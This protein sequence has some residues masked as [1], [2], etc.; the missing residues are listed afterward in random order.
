MFGDI[1]NM[2]NVENGILNMTVLT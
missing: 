2:N 1:L